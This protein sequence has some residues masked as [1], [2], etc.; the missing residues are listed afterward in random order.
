MNHHRSTTHPRT[1]PHTR[2]RTTRPDST[3]VVTAGIDGSYASLDAADWAAREALRHGVP[4]RLLHAGA[5]PAHS[6]RVRRL[7]AATERA[8]CLLDRAA[9]TLSYV[10]PALEIHAQ[11]PAGSTVAALLAASA[12]AETLVLGSRGLS[13][14]PGFLVGSVAAAVTARAERPVVLVR[15]GER[16]ED[17][18]TPGEGGAPSR[19]T[20][21]RPVV[22]GLDPS[23]PGDA[24]TAYAFDAASVREAPLH[25]VHAWTMAPLDAYAPGRVLPADL[26][27]LERDNRQALSAVLE[28][29]RRTYPQVR[30]V[31]QVSFGRAGHQLLKAACG[32]SLLVIG[33]R[34]AAGSHLG[35]TAHSAMHHVTCP[36]AVVPH[37]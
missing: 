15:A 24:L 6:T 8:R 35:R 3:R 30:V 16:P 4:L 37:D 18:H 34:R 10:H 22:L 13:G 23:R 21:Y 5:A 12:E 19:G 29:W 20:P 31:E 26:T 7:P 27:G 17:A 33:R 36:I 2:S 1:H 32:A 25:V 28:P 14:L 9:I 11:Q